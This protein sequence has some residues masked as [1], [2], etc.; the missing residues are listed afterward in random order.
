MKPSQKK[1]KES[2]LDIIISFGHKP[3]STHAQYF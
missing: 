3:Q 1:S 2:D